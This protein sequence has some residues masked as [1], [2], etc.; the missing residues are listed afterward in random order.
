LTVP[1]PSAESQLQF[2]NDVQAL[3]EDGQFTATYKFAL[4]IALA[5]LSVESGVDDDRP[6]PVPLTGVAAK[7]VEYYWQQSAPFAGAGANEILLQ[8]RGQ[9]A[10]VVRRGSRQ[11]RDGQP[12]RAS[13]GGAR[14]LA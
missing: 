8:N 1:I 5:D 13:G 3:L 7:F 6:L 9:Q 2:L 4:L 12:A 11:A 10:A 14:D